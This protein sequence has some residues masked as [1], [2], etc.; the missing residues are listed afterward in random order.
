MTGWFLLAAGTTLV[1]LTYSLLPW[2]AAFGMQSRLAT[3]HIASSAIQITFDP[4]HKWLARCTALPNDRVQ[5]DLP[6]QVSDVPEGLDVRA[7]GLNLSVEAPGRALWQSHEKPWLQVNSEAEVTSLQTTMDGA[8]YRQIRNEPV[9]L[10]G[11]MYLAL[12]GYSQQTDIPFGNR[13][14]P[15]P[16]AGLCSASQQASSARMVR[17]GPSG[18]SAFNGNV[19]RYMLL[20]HSAYRSPPDI[21]SASFEHFRTD[22]FRGALSYSPFP[23]E[24]ILSPVGQYFAS[25]TLQRQIAAVTVASTKPVAFIRREFEIDGMRLRDFETQPVDLAR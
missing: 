15:V 13:A 2:T 22:V 10:R 8:I 7:D 16:G 17:S 23:A 11:Q 14:V 3:A 5:I 25:A 4:D 21:L 18:P 12:A 9:K 20:C 19:Q 24:F 6:I 1:V